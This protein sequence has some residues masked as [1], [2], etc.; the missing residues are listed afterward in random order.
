MEVAIVEVLIEAQPE[1]HCQGRHVPGTTREV[2][3]LVH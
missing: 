3:N 1:L 2:V